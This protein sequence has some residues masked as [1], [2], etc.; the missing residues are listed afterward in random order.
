MTVTTSTRAAATFPVFKPTGSGYRAG[1]WG[2]VS[3]DAK[4]APGDTLVMCKLPKG[5]VIIGGA[6]RGEKWDSAGAGTACMTLNIGV[7]QPVITPQGTTVSTASTSDCLAA[8]WAIGS[9][10]AAIP[11][12][13]PEASG[14]NIP[15]G[16]LLVSKGPLTCTEDC[17]VIIKSITSAATTYTAVVTLTVDYY[18]A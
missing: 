12:V 7:D 3:L 18:M 17:N 16:G 13:H 14:R 11:G 6:L 5:A 9:E 2:T 15:L 8:A 4:F 10:I 1:A